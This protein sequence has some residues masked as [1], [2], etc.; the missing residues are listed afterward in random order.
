MTF[1]SDKGEYFMELDPPPPA[2]PGLAILKLLIV[3]IE[4]TA[5]Y[6]GSQ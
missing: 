2:S 3:K 5:R 4:D 6:L 1:K